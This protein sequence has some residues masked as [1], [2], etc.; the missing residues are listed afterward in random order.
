MLIKVLA[1]N[2]LH[3]KTNFKNHYVG[4]VSKSGTMNGLNARLMQL[5]FMKIKSHIAMRFVEFN[6]IVLIL[7]SGILKIRI[8]MH[9]SII[10]NGIEFSKGHR[11][12]RPG[13]PLLDP[14]SGPTRPRNTASSCHLE[15][16]LV[17]NCS[18]HLG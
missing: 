17:R 3:L 8:I 10:L 5:R 11:S 14:K 12:V 18:L 13:R 1:L 15:N 7:E 6:S 4:K 9:G 16:I 2:S